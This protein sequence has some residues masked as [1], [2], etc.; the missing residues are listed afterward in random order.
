MADIERSIQALAPSPPVG[1]AVSRSLKPFG[2]RGSLAYLGVPEEVAPQMSLED[3]H[4]YRHP[5]TGVEVRHLATLIAVARTGSF[6][7][8][9]SELGY[10]QSAVSQQISSL[11]QVVGTRLVD[12]R[13]GHRIVTLTPAGELLLERSIGI[14]AELRAARVDVSVSDDHSG[15]LIRLLIAADVAPRILE[16]LLPEVMREMPGIRLRVTE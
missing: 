9:A 14:V 13:R 5:W 16:R 4:E 7:Q 1:R 15:P 12:R 10:V 6:R 2:G 3:T 11:E 8:A